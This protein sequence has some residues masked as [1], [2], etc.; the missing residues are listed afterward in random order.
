MK[1]QDELNELTKNIELLKEQG[2]NIHSLLK[3]KYELTESEQL[4]LLE[5]TPKEKKAFLKSKK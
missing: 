2:F 1:N 3:N 4:A 5:M